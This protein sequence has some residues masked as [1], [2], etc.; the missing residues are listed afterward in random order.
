MTTFEPPK[1]FNAITAE[2][3]GKKKDCWLYGSIY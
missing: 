1:Y 2:K 3:R